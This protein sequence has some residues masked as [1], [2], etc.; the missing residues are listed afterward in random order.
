MEDQDNNPSFTCY[1]C[2]QENHY[3]PSDYTDSK[4][5]GELLMEMYRMKS[6]KNK[7]V[8]IICNNPK[9]NKKNTV[10]ISYYA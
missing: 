3:D 9:C 7:D 2:K 10:T 8:I 6:L 5:G 4:R 1:N